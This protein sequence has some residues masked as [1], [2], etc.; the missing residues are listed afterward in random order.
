MTCFSG[1][2]VQNELIVM[3][4]LAWH[5]CDNKPSNLNQFCLDFQMDGFFSLDLENDTK[6]N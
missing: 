3:Q 1:I 4:L 5:S 2:A 6:V